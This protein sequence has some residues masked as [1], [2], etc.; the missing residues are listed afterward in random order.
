MDTNLEWIEGG[1]LTAPQGFAAGGA[2]A[3]IKT[4]GPEPRLDVGILASDRPAAVAGLFTRNAVVGEALRLTRERVQS[5][6]ARAVVINSGNANC[7]TGEQ[8]V[9]DALRMA[10]LAAARLG[11]PVEQVLVGSTGVIGRPLPMDRIERGIAAITATP[12]GG[13]EF[14]RAMMTTDTYAK[15]RAVRFSAGGRTYIVGGGAKGSGMIHPDLATMFGFLTTDA[16]ADAAWLRDTLRGVCD[17]SFNMV[18]VDMD[19]STCDMVIAFANGAA[20]G[21]PIDARHPVAP[22]LTAAVEAVAVAL[23]RELARDGEGARTL[24]EVLV[25][26]AASEADARQAA[27]TITSSPLVKTMVT[28]RDPN[29]GR[30]MMAAGRSGVAMDEHSASV[31][32]GPHCALDH[33]VPTTVDLALISRAMDAPEVQLRIDLGRGTH[34]ATAWGCDL[35][36]GYVRINA[37]YT[38]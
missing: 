1:G 18:D 32:I 6:V 36:E 9:R 4:H 20:G 10:A 2:Y 5:G 3:G 19:T 31:W 8:G 35:T 15:H 27:R 34:T 16:P 21:E 17:R 23:A 33:G 24:I 22:A 14:S 7:V 12:T 28:G 29:W 30:V 26:G 11:V 25:Q 38:T 37:D 13:D